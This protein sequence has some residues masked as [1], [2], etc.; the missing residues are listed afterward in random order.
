MS[1]KVFIGGEWVSGE[2]GEF[3]DVINPATEEVVDRV[4]LCT[5]DDAKSALEAA[6]HAQESWQEVPASE[7]ARLVWRLA[8]LIEKD[9][10][11]LARLV[12]TE[13]GKPLKEAREDVQGAVEYCRYYAGLA[14]QVEGSVLPGEAR[15]RTVMLLKIPVGVVVGITPWNFPAAMVTRKMAPALVA[16]DGFV[17]KP[18]TYTPLTA[19]EIMKLAEKAGA[20]RG[21]VNLVT[22][23]GS[24]VGDELVR[25]PMTD[26]VTMTGSV[27]TG[28]RIMEAASQNLTRV[29]LEL[30]GKAPFIV[31]KDADLE[32]A[33]RSALWARYW[34]AGQTCICNER[35]YVHEDLY[36]RFR[37]KYVKAVQGLRLGDPTRSGVDMGPLVASEQL[38][39]VEAS[40]RKA[41]EEGA[42]LIVGGSRPEGPGFD[43]GYWFTPTVLEDVDQD[44]E[45]VRK[46]IFGPV[47]PLARFESLDEVIDY[48]NDSEYG[49]ASYVFTQDVRAAMKA[50]HR[51]KF[52]ETYINQVGP[53]TV[54]GYHAGF[55][56]SGIGGDGSRYGFDHYFHLKTVYLDYSGRPE[57]PH[58]FPYD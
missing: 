8:D 45:I 54:H 35:T 20:P 49:L 39:K 15:E 23:P 44:M 55:R 17:L 37:E 27:E 32:W 26:L 29:V 42:R 16:G 51:L 47:T 13:E 5:R 41:V 33:V 43:R 48:A 31:W 46:E 52:G 1:Q 21:L 40:I 2:S 7:R 14:R 56:K 10:E 28:Q 22:G 38:E 58:I 11:R 57:A 34:N 4:P 24:T 19:I 25:N 30:G 12:T 50:A 36:D 18:S 53:E 6:T 3:F 9:L